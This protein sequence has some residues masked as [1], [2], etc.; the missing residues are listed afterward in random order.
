MAK[1]LCKEQKLAYT[2]MD[3]FWSFLGKITT[4]D[5]TFLFYNEQP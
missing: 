4:S 2:A 3:L 5:F 1:E